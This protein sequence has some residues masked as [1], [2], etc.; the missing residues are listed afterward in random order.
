MCEVSSS[1]KFGKGVA[2]MEDSEEEEEEVSIKEKRTKIRGFLGCW[3]EH[4]INLEVHNVFFFF[5]AG[6]DL[7]QD[8]LTMQMIRIMDKLWLSEGLDLRMI[9]FRCIGTGHNR[10]IQLNNIHS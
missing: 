1:Y 10:G 9:T 3:P 5:Q 7:R 6:D 2:D 8:M 4:L